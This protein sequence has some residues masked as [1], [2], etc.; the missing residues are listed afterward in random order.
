[1]K[2]MRRTSAR[3]RAPDVPRARPWLAVGAAVVFG[4]SSGSPTPPRAVVRFG[5]GFANPAV[6]C[7]S[8]VRGSFRF[9]TDA[10][11]NR[12]GNPTRR[13]HSASIE[14]GDKRRTGQEDPDA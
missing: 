5:F 9:L 4:S 1:M 13:H 12:T 10:G 8:S 6:E 2:A 14:S 3:R 7:A 11:E